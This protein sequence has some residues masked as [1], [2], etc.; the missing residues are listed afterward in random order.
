MSIEYSALE[1]FVRH[2]RY[3]YNKLYSCPGHNVSSEI[4]LVSVAKMTENRVSLY[5]WLDNF[6]IKNYFFIR[7]LLIISMPENFRFLNMLCAS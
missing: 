7:D 1:I 5:Y 3:E 2:Q 6:L 4:W